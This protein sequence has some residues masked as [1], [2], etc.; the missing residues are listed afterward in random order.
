MY[1]KTCKSERPLSGLETRMTP[2]VA[3]LVS[4]SC[5]S[6]RPLSGLETC[7]F[8][9]TSSKFILLAKVNDRLAV[10]SHLLTGPSRENRYPCKSERP[11][12]GLE[13][14]TKKKTT[15]PSSPCKSE[16]PLSGL[17]SSSRTTRSV[18]STQFLQK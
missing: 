3:V 9:L 16:R 14:S 7:R 18:E 5:K 17:E 2:F 15:P 8:N 11:L 4:G 10:W 13:S 1:L 6:E 12:S